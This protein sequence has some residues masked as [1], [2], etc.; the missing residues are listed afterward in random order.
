[1][2]EAGRMA[3]GAKLY[4]HHLAGGINKV[5]QRR[6]DD[7]VFFAEIGDVNNFAGKN[8]CDGKSQARLANLS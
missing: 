4:R 7:K 2:E 5:S 8:P 1:M 3:P 6:A